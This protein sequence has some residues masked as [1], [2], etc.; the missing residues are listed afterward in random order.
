MT[1]EFALPANLGSSQDPPKVLS[2][3]HMPHNSTQPFPISADEPVGQHFQVLRN[4]NEVNNVNLNNRQ[5]IGSLSRDG[6]S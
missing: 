3:A 6:L 1:A 5:R 4:P 2:Q